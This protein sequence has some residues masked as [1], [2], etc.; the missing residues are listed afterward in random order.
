[1]KRMQIL[2]LLLILIPIVAFIIFF[3]VYV[4]P[5]FSILSVL[6]SLPWG[7]SVLFWT[8]IIGILSDMDKAS[9]AIATICKSLSGVSFWFEKNAVQK[10]VEATIS[11]SSKKVND[12]GVSLLPNGIAV[13]WVEP[14]NREAFLREG[15]V[16][17]CL[18]PSQNEE[19]N[20][21]IATTLYVSDDLVRE[22][23]R[24]INPAI[25]NSLSLA[26]SRKML[27]SDRKLSAVKI[28]NDV[29]V[30][31]AV[32][33]EPLIRKY[34]PLVEKID[35]QGLLTRVLL[36]EFSFLD[37]KLGPVVSNPQ[38][39][40]E[41]TKFTELLGNFVEKTKDE[42][43]QLRIRGE[44]IRAGLAPI[45]RSAAE[46]NLGLYINSSY[47]SY[48]EGIE[49]VYVMAI[50][51]NMDLAKLVA[52]TMERKNIY[53]K[54]REWHFRALRNGKS[55]DTFVALMVRVSPTIKAFEKLREIV[56]S[57]HE[58]GNN[59]GMAVIATKI[60]EAGIDYKKIGYKKFKNFV[61]LASE[62]EYVE[63][64]EQDDGEIVILPRNG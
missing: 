47:K 35:S 31:P 61:T 38:I 24:F 3:V 51:Y 5:E 21:A 13:K 11:S 1:M 39:Q 17:V 30:K 63:I 40:A 29:F 44:A 23:Q 8:L 25:M 36:R 58:T 20:L 41:T 53:R 18:E 7:L 16:V 57:L 26:I 14:M 10:R 9:S 4:I 19:R 46:F 52:K 6:N 45:A 60:Q 2:T 64:V 27:M 56:L 32:E 33:D 15:S 59:T 50:G 54:K 43:V 12:E 42:D 55:V 62:E 22:S 37:A 48:K 28:L 49:T 34:L